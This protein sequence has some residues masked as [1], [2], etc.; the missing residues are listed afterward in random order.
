MLHALLSSFVHNKHLKLTD[1]ESFAMLQI[2]V[3]ISPNGFEARL[4]PGITIINLMLS[5]SIKVQNF[6]IVLQFL[7]VIPRV[8]QNLAYEVIFRFRGFV[9]FEKLIQFPLNLLSGSFQILKKRIGYIVSMRE[10]PAHSVKY[11]AHGA[12]MR[13]TKARLETPV[14]NRIG[15]FSN[16]EQRRRQRE[17]HKFAYLESKAIALHAL[18]VHLFIFVHFLA[19]DRKTTT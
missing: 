3:S 19:V 7:K 4:E 13:L 16:T 17:R 5:E 14:F 15:S 9:I 12:T 6:D 8:S 18:L 1:I 11:Q 10:K 2:N